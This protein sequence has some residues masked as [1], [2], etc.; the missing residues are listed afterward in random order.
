MAKVHMRG[1]TENHLG[2]RLRMQLATGE[3]EDGDALELTVCPP[4]ALPRVAW[5]SE[6]KAEGSVYWLVPN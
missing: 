5:P 3:R 6:A 1:R 2:K 4:G